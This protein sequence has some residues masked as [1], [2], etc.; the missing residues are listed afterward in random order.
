LQNVKL[1][2]MIVYKDYSVD[3]VGEMKHISDSAADE[4]ANARDRRHSRR[5]E[6]EAAK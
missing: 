1:H 2:E 6:A 5:T 4:W 3:R